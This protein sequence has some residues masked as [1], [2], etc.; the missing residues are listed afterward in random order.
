MK[1][2]NILS[3]S[4]IKRR[5]TKESPPSDDE[6]TQ[7][8]HTNGAPSEHGGARWDLDS[9][10]DVIEGMRNINGLTQEQLGA[11]SNLR[12]LFNPTYSRRQSGRSVQRREAKVFGKSP[13]YGPKNSPLMTEELWRCLN[14]VEENK[15]DNDQRMTATA[16]LANFGGHIFDKVF[17]FAPHL[18]ESQNAI[19][20]DFSIN[21][22][23]NRS[24]LRGSTASLTIDSLYDASPDGTGEGVRQ[25]ST[26]QRRSG[27]P[28]IDPFPRTKSNEYLFESEVAL[29]SRVYCPPEW[30]ALTINARS[31]LCRILSWENL[32]KWDFSVLEVEKLS[33]ETLHDKN[34]ALEVGQSCPLLF[35]GWAILCAPMAQQAMEGSIEF[36]VKT[37]PSTTHNRSD[38]NSFGYHFVAD[39]DVSPEKVCNFLRQ[40]ECRYQVENPYHNNIHAADVTQTLHCLLQFIEVDVIECLFKSEDIFS[41]ILA[42][43]F[44]DVGHPGTNNLF[45]KHARTPF[46]IRYNDH[47][48]LESMHSAL[49]HSLLMG[50]K[51]QEEWDVFRN[52]SDSQITHARD[53]MMSSIL[54]TD[55]STHFHSLEKIASGVEKVKASYNASASRTSPVGIFAGGDKQEA[56]PILSILAKS[57]DAKEDND[58][59]KNEELKKECC[60][61]ARQVLSFLLHAADISNPAK[62]HDLAVYWANK[63]LDEFFA[64]GDIEHAKDLPISPLCDRKTVKKPDSQIGFLKFV[65][66][67]TYDLLGK[68][69]PRVKEE[70]MPIIGE[71]IRYWTKE[72][73][74]LSLLKVAKV[75]ATAAAMTP[76]RNT[77]DEEEHEGSITNKGSKQ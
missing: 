13:G 18:D 73:T 67:P 74:R 51:K 11:I 16:V 48:I 10:F 28:T 61:L 14:E 26:T 54:D 1:A 69:I 58:E 56:T 47:S 6:S 9:C 57:L 37:K 52:W 76:R 3:A 22:R 50:G 15:E 62:N 40:I 42:A 24:S 77:I 36:V 71:N 23:G 64:Q 20:S 27:D 70:L 41:I 45:Q 60:Q 31:Q 68:I 66:Q 72:K 39:L 30:N 44:H 46:A 12:A 4:L 59:N 19:Q 55:M 21:I 38:Y 75:V 49:G 5:G 2:R 29:S 32:S 43:T 17:S 8:A 34:D 53:V 35:V 65:V 33:G 7:T 25:G 63:A